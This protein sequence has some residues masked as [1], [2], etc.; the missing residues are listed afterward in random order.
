MKLYMYCYY[1]IDVAAP[2]SSEHK[3]SNVPNCTCKILDHPTPGYGHAPYCM[4]PFSRKHPPILL[5]MACDQVISDKISN[6]KNS[7]R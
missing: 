5:K 2:K 7:K 3:P 4:H 1:I 6:L